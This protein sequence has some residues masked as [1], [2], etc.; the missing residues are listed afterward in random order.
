MWFC[1]TIPLD[2]PE[3]GR[4]SGKVFLAD[5][6]LSFGRT[7]QNYCKVTEKQCLHS[8][9]SVDKLIYKILELFL[10]LKQDSNERIGI[11]AKKFKLWSRENKMMLNNLDHFLSIHAQNSELNFW[12]NKY[13]PNVKFQ[14]AC[15][16]TSWSECVLSLKW[17]AVSV[18]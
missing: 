6:R 14:G 2:S 1:W 18:K 9:G 5:T 10:Q 16:P 13:P 12:Q 3:K 11:R 15:T 17:R 7:K 4:C 8:E